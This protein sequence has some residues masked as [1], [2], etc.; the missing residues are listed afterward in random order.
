MTPWSVNKSKVRTRGEGIG[1]LEGD[2][3]RDVD[4]EQMNLTMLGDEMTLIVEDDGGVIDFIINVSLRN[5]TTNDPSVSL[6]GLLAQKISRRRSSLINSLVNIW[7]RF[8]I[9]RERSNSIWR[10][11]ALWKDLEKKEKDINKYNQLRS[12]L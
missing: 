10:V 4:I 6:L 11:P 3:A 1:F 8:S 12:Y 5:G 2:L 9:F 7:N